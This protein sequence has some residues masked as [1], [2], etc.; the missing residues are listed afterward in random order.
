ME[1]LKDC[2]WPKIAWQ[3][4]VAAR[5]ETSFAGAQLFAQAQKLNTVSEYPNVWGFH[6]N[7]CL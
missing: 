7:Q 2:Y 6:S 4:T 1:K 5:I 3:Q